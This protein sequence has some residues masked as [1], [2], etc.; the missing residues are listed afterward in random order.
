MSE[1]KISKFICRVKCYW[2][3]RIWEVGAELEH[4]GRPPQHFEHVGGADLPPIP[5]PVAPPAFADS[6]PP[7]SASALQPAPVIAAPVV[8]PPAPTTL[9]G[10]APVPVSVADAVAKANSG[11]PV[12]LSQL[13]GTAPV[14][15]PPAPEVIPP[16][17][18]L[19]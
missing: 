7:V 4:V 10:I 6:K 18:P 3:E 17:D 14:V 13:A 12:S 2:Q 15:P 11:Q 1:Q 16:V 19:S 8:P 5:A 9:A